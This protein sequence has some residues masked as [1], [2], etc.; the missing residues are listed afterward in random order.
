MLVS[1]STSR[2]GDDGHAAARHAARHAF[3]SRAAVAV[4]VVAA[5]AALALS[6]FNPVVRFGL[7]TACAVLL[8]L[9][10]DGV[11]LPAL[12]TRGRRGEG[13]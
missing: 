4:V 5:F 13:V 1:E 8:A 9:V 12:A 10:S 7:L 2:D 11:L 3:G 6:S